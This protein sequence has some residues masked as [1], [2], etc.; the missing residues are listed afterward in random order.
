MALQIVMVLIGMAQLNMPQCFLWYIQIQIFQPLSSFS[1]YTTFN[2]IYPQ[3]IATAS[4]FNTKLFYNIGKV[5]STEARAM[6]NNG[7]AGLTFW[8]PNM[9]I[10]RDPRWGRGQES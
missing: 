3:P 10:Y 7:Q 5:I 6:F 1:M 2:H 8:A 4:S 9:N